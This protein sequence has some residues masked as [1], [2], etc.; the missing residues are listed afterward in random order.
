MKFNPLLYKDFYKA[1]H[2]SQYP[3]GTE[4]VYSNMTPRSS[5]SPYAFIQKVVVFGPE[6]FAQEYLMRQ[7]NDGF[8]Y[9]PKKQIIE[10][11]KRRLD[12]ALGKDLVPIDHVVALH[13]MGHLPV[14]FKSLPEGSLCL[15]RVPCFTIEN[16]HSD[17]FWLTNFLETLLSCALWHPMTTATI[18]FEYR[19]LFQQFAEETSDMADF[20]PW[21]GH[22]FS[23]RGHTSLH[24]AIVSGA[25]HL[26]SFTGTDTIPAID[27]LERYYGA[28]CETELIGGSVPATEHSVMCMGGKETEI[29]TFERLI[30]EVY[31]TGIISIVSDTW[32]YWK[33][34]TE[35]VP[36]LKDKILARNGKV[37][38]RPDSGDPVKIL[39]G[40]PDAEGAAKIGTIAHLWNIFQGTVNSRGFRQLDSHVGTIYGDSIT[41]ERAAQICSQLKERGFAS[42]N[43]IAGIGSYTYQYNTRDTFGFA[44]KAT[45][46]VMNGQSFDIFKDPKTGDGTKRSAKGLLRVNANFTL[47]EQVSESEVD[48]GLLELVFKNG[49]LYRHTPLAKI[50]E[51]LEAQ[52]KISK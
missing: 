25:A 49:S 50:R 7:F 19:K 47:S 4:R 38:F 35:V 27:F 51:R 48:D 32:D 17:F 3:K 45:H 2:R 33:V 36:K 31:P 22:D 30:T 52:L 8:F 1:D 23:M 14:Q 34:M 28:N 40:D 46:G 12:T 9:Q 44:M 6:Y 16:T 20:V 18:A 37:V 15:L 43:W 41:L 13:R 24:S 11:Y 26:L 39:C 21:Q 10:K 5:R 29:E 42:T